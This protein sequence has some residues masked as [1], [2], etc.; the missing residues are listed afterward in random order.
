MAKFYNIFHIFSTENVATDKDSLLIQRK[1]LD[2]S[3][4]DVILQMERNL[5]VLES[6]LLDMHHLR[7]G[8]RALSEEMLHN[9]LSHVRKAEQKL[10]ILKRYYK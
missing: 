4:K 2:V 5:L 8:K 3:R 10:N 6:D 1:A 9:W 7:R